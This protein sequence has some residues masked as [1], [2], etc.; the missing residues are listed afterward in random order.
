[1]IAGGFDVV[2]G[3]LVVVVGMH[4]L[5]VT[6]HWSFKMSHRLWVMFLQVGGSTRNI[7]PIIAQNLSYGATTEY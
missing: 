2:T 3:A 1:M 7:I 4:W 5:Q 6:G